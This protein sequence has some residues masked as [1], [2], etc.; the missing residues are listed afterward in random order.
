MWRTW[1]GVEVGLVGG[2]FDTG[3]NGVAVV[4]AEKQ[5]RQSVERRKVHGLVG[6]ALVDRAIAEERHRQPSAAA[7]LL[8]EGVSAGDRQAARD[9]G[10][11]AHDAEGL[12]AQVHRSATPAGPARLQAEDLLHHEARFLAHPVAQPGVRRGIEI[13]GVKRV[14]HLCDDLVMGAVR[15]VHHRVQRQRRETARRARLLP[16]AGMGGPVD[17]AALVEKQD[18]FLEP[19]SGDQQ[20]RKPLCVLGRQARPVVIIDRKAAHPGCHVDR[21][22]LHR[23]A[24]IIARHPAHGIAPGAPVRGCV[25]SGSPQ[26]G[27]LPR[28]R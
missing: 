13:V 18:L 19:P 3:R 20:C 25:M 28:V 10:I 16:E 24:F 14:D 27:F 6:G 17:E 12:A 22:I 7:G 8:G 26:A 21:G 1:A 5:H 23:G 4:F 11:G 15:A 9:D 2:L